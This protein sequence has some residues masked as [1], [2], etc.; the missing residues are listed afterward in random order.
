MPAILW[1]SQPGF[2]K[3]FILKYFPRYNLSKKICKFIKFLRI[4]FNINNYS[5]KRNTSANS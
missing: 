3:K 4:R 2:R 5:I 1:E